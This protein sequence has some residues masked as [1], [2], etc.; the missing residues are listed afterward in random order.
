VAGLL[1]VQADPLVAALGQGPG[2][3]LVR[4][5][6]AALSEE[7]WFLLVLLGW[8]R[9]R[10]ALPQDRT[11]LLA[12]GLVGL[13]FALAESLAPGDPMG[14]LLA[15]PGHV[16]SGFLLGHFLARSRPPAG[17]PRPGLLGLGLLL[18]VVLHLIWDFSVFQLEVPEVLIEAR[19][20]WVLP[21]LGVL[22]VQL[23]LVLRY[24]RVPQDP[25][26]S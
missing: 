20:M 16:A 11:P 24:G 5:L 19:A 15:V 13:G 25:P 18:V 2:A 14:R 4:A 26:A 8:A 23:G 22:L 17:P 3:A 21:I 6:A 10:G 9:G 12:G 1:Q 7:G